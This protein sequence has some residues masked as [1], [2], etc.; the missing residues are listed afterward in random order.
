MKSKDFDD[1]TCVVCGNTFKYMFNRPLRTTCNHKCTL[2]LPYPPPPIP[3][4]EFLQRMN[5][6][7][8]DSPDLQNYV[9]T[10]EEYELAISTGIKWSEKSAHDN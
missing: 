8:I 6:A 1:I 10:I 9:P 2:Q 4:I 5:K 3:T 7:N